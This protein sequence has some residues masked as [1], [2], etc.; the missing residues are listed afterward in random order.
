MKG[1]LQR[2]VLCPRLFTLCLNSVAWRLRATEGYR[3]SKP[4]DVKVTYLLYINVMTWRFLLPSKA[5]C[6]ECWR[7]LKERCRIS[8]STGMRKSAQW[9]TSG[10]RK[11]E[12][13]TIMPAWGRKTIQIPG[14][15]RERSTGW[16][17]GPGVCGYKEYLRRISLIWSSPLFD[18]HLV[19]AT[20]QY[21]L[22]VLRYLIW[23]QHWPLS[24]VRD[25]YRAA[26][27]IIVENGGKH[28]ASLTSL[29]YLPTEKG[30]RGLWSVEQEYKLAKIKSLLKL[31][32]ITDQTVESVR[33]FEEQAVVSGHQSLVKEA[34][35]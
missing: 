17:A 15:A 4:K 6:T 32:Q 3:L 14:G 19:Q 18:C 29:L 27:K 13:S 28:P 31:Y 21:A 20:N 35:K 8:T 2:D 25:I 33:E 26:Q 34:A 30:G 23:T 9:Y 24:E 16:T 1:L 12:T 7:K 22:P 11:D 10:I 5:S